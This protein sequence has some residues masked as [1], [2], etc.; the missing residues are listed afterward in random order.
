LFLLAGFPTIYMIY[1]TRSQIFSPPLVN[2][3]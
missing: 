2:I 1:R 3:Y